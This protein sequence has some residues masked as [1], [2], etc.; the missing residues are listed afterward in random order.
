[1][2]MDFKQFQK[3]M[4]HLPIK[5]YEFPSL[6]VSFAGVTR[7]SFGEHCVIMQRM[8]AQVI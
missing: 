7:Y 8:T 1:M 4:P 3:L 6:V 5:K 2:S